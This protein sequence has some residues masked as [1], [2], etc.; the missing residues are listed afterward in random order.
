MF[1][2]GEIPRSLL[3][4]LHI[5]SSSAKKKWSDEGKRKESEIT[6]DFLKKNLLNK[7]KKATKAVWMKKRETPTHIEHEE[8]S[9]RDGAKRKA[10]TENK[11]EKHKMREVKIISQY[12]SRRI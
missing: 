5:T 7:E 11:M 9:A 12:I 2:N 3:L 4:T 1:L 10:K 8:K 6:P